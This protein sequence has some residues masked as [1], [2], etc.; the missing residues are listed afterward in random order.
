MP[1]FTLI[2]WPIAVAHATVPAGHRPYGP[3]AHTGRM[4]KGPI[5][6]QGAIILNIPTATCTLRPKGL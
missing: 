4:A 1:H 3:Q 2:C 6:L 5:N